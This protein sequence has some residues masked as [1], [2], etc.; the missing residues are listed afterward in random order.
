MHAEIHVVQFGIIFYMHLEIYLISKN[1]KTLSNFVKLINNKS[2]TNTYKNH[3]LWVSC[4]PC[5]VEALVLIRQHINFLFLILHM[6]NSVLKNSNL[7]FNKS[8]N[9]PQ[10]W[11]TYYSL[12]RFQFR[13]FRITIFSTLC[14]SNL[15]WLALSTTSSQKTINYCSC[16][17]SVVAIYLA[18]FYEVSDSTHLPI[19]IYD[20]FE[21][22]LNI[23]N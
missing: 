2:Y 22:C 11:V 6:V 4:I 15:Y 5:I 18:S 1:N 8:S 19:A 10:L 21:I 7:C 3:T 9:V 13:F 14:F 17:T 23:W 16:S 20:L 12:K